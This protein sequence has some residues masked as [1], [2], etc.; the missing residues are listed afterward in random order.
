M[1]LN[2][3]TIFEL[4]R[5]THRDGSHHG[6]I[7]R[8]RLGTVT[9]TDKDIRISGTY[10][11]NDGKCKLTWLDGKPIPHLLPVLINHEDTTKAK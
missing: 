6:R 8:E 10:G 11:F 9:T 2:Q 4:E 1:S 7:N 3:K 5:L